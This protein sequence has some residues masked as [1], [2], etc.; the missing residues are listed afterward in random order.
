M[1]VPDLRAASLFVLFFVRLIPDTSVQSRQFSQV[2][3]HGPDNLSPMSKG[4]GRETEFHQK[5]SQQTTNN[6]RP[7]RRTAQLDEILHGTGQNTQN[8][9]L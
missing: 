4:V 2:A 1:P 5:A 9:L 6:L 7:G 3:F 8:Y